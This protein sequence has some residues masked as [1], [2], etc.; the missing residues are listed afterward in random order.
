LATS[1]VLTD[2]RST[3]GSRVLA[4][5]LNSIFNASG[6]VAPLHFMQNLKLYDL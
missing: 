3:H 4:L 1:T 6:H 2:I 5:G